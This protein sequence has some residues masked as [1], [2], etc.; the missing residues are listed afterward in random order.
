MH[1]IKFL[2]SC[3]VFFTLFVDTLEA[4]SVTAIALFTD[5][6]MLSIDG[7]KAKIV[8]AGSEYQGV[9]LITS[10]TSEAVIEVNG[11]RETLTLNGTTVVSEQLGAFDKKSDAI[12]EMRVGAGGFF[13]SD[14]TINGR[15]IKF[16]V[17]TGASLVVLSSRQANSIGLSYLD[18]ERG[19][20]STASGTAPMY[21]IRL[22][23]ISVGGIQLN[24][25]DAG[26]IEGGFPEVPLLG[27]TFLS[28]VDM[29]R[30][31]NLMTL[32]ER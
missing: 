19:L 17:D 23:S 31:G 7:K 24:D 26:V 18:G 2:F 10:N 21:T 6:A 4:K 27:M 22:N 16:L 11:A 12:V 5:R 1:L 20:A 9:K 3:V 14:G 32:K 8:R 13:E 30:S 28:K 25:I 15:G 29:T